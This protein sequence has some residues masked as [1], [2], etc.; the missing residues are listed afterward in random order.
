MNV[1]IPLKLDKESKEIQ[2]SAYIVITYV[3][4]IIGRIQERAKQQA[5][6]HAG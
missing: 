4:P 2:I 6:V 1:A 5:Y 3:L